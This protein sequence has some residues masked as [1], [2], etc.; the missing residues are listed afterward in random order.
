MSLHCEA[1]EPREITVAGPASGEM[2]EWLPVPVFG[3]HIK[4]RIQ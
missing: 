2:P 4:K 1:C 3:D